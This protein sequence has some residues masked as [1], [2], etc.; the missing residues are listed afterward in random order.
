[1]KQ[2][3]F[4]IIL[5]IKCII[6]PAQNIG[7]GT[8]N[9]DASAAL[10]LKSISKGLL[11]P[12]MNSSQRLNISTPADGLIVYD[13]YLKRLYQYQ[14]GIWRYFLNNGQW[15]QA[16]TRNFVFNNTDS[17]GIGTSAPVERLHVAGNIFATGDIL[18]QGDITMNNSTGKLQFQNAAD[19]KAYIQLSG[20]NIRM[21]T[22]D[23]NSTGN[24]IIRMNG[25]DRVFVDEIGRLGIGKSNPA[26]RVDVEGD[27]NVAG[28]LLNI[29][30][31]GY[32]PLQPLAY[33][34]VFYS[35]FTETINYTGTP[36]C[37]VTYIS[38]T[39]RYKVTCAGVTENSVI[40]ANSALPNI[41]V[42]AIP[43]NGF[44]YVSGRDFSTFLD[45]FDFFRFIVYDP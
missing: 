26:A 27:V 23:G 40:K 6:V 20:D 45:E 38:S 9:P 31:T 42:T 11:A 41:R 34:S 43:H 32:S 24:M 29:S 19:N 2:T 30:N 37:T 36:N 3:I 33:G 17:I 21:G 22:N 25:T 7:I 44:F 15:S 5:L 8:T 4:C 1:M 13:N 28:N 12:S 39:G 10:H 35:F 14:G 18:T 16:S